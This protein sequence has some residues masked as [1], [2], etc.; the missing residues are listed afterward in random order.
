MDELLSSADHTLI[1]A[2][3]AEAESRTSGEIV[4]YIVG[5][6]APY[7]EIVWKAAVQFGIVATL[8]IFG[9]SMFYEGW[10]LSWLFS[11][12]GSATLIVS[13]ALIGAAMARWIPGLERHFVSENARADAVRQRGLQAFVEEEI[14]STRDRTGILIY[15]SMLERRVEVF[16]DSGINEKVQPE[17]WAHVVE[18]V[19]LGMKSAGLGAGLATAIKRCGDLLVENGFD[20]RSDDENE[21]GDGVRIRES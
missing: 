4:P 6:S 10:S 12:P 7:R 15:V 8:I 16:G 17:D 13:S 18:D 19:L 3:V 14:F 9:M 5:R 21:L 2:A 11:A 20:V 1:E